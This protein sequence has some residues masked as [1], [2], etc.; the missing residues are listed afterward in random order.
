VLP[1][2]ETEFLELLISRV[3]EK[4]PTIA[5]V[6]ECH[7]DM[8]KLRSFGFDAILSKNNI[9]R[10]GSNIGWHDSIVSADSSSIYHAIVDIARHQRLQGEPYK[11]HYSADH[12]EN[13]LIK[14]VI[15]KSPALMRPLSALTILAGS[16]PYL[17][18]AGHETIGHEN[19]E[20]FVV[21]DPTGRYPSF[22]KPTSIAWLNASPSAQKDFYDINQDFLKI[23]D[24]LGEFV[25]EETFHEQHIVGY[26]L[27]PRA[28]TAEN[29]NRGAIVM[30][31]LEGQER[32]VVVNCEF[33]P[34]ENP[35]TIEYLKKTIAT[36]SYN[37]SV[38]IL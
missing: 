28:R 31:N 16:G 17:H 36:P 15:N 7:S 9:H 25:I 3:K 37:Y 18:V 10:K 20:E 23:R 24:L 2:P 14:K 35:G 34:N 38:E 29:W 21:S 5:F 27:R 26:I 33:S 22:E 13:P 19:Q 4:F 30:A 6:A 1:R 32:T 8:D 11:V 12:D